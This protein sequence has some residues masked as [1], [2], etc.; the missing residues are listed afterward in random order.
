[1]MM[2]LNI[3]P[4]NSNFWFSTLWWTSKEILSLNIWWDF[5]LTRQSVDKARILWQSAACSDIVS[6]SSGMINIRLPSY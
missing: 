2:I 6:E 1:V 3:I 5:A 4:F